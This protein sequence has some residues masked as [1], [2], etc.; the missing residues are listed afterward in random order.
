MP[1][2]GPM[3]ATPSGSEGLIGPFRPPTPLVIGL[4]GGIAAGKSKVASLFGG[5]RI[6]HVDAD[7]HARAASEDP[8]VVQEVA[9]QI[10]DRFVRDGQLDRQ[11]LGDHV[12]RDPAA[13]AKLEGIVHPRVRARILSELEQAKHD[14][15]SVLLD[16]PLLFEAGL[17]ELCDTIV[18]VHASDAVRQARAKSRGWADDELAR[19]EANQLPLAEKRARSQHVVD[20]D[21]DL[22]FTAH[23][24]D[25]VLAKLEKNA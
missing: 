19:R 2:D 18:F 20:N 14:D 21:G 24:V 16:V 4:V 9:K 5:R 17:F 15:V 8:E 13:K 6:R 23:A 11:A 1:H 22:K 3:L 10:G 25:E 7:F 12:F